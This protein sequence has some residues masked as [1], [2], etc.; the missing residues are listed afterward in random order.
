MPF[1]FATS[2]VVAII[3]TGSMAERT[4]LKPIIGYV[5]LMQLLIY[6]VC[7]S[8]AW[9]I[10]GDGGFLRKLGYFDRGGAVVMYQTGALAGLLGS[11]I[12]GPRYGLFMGDKK[13]KKEGTETP[14]SI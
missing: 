2:L 9:N 14:T 10:E 12:L 4:K 11:I 5:F 3:A 13:K 8:W 7:M 1:Y 6:P